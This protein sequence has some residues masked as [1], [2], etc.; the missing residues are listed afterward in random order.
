MSTPSFSLI[1]QASA[2]RS[3][4]E[5]IARSWL[6][7]LEPQSAVF[8]LAEVQEQLVALGVGRVHRQLV[9][10]GVHVAGGDHQVLPAVEVD[11]RELGPPAE[12]GPRRDSQAA[13]G[14]R[15]FEHRSSEF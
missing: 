4:E 7:F 5:C 11:V 2:D 3:L 14:S 9:D 12:V 10:L 15:D 6:D 13:G 1:D 8:L